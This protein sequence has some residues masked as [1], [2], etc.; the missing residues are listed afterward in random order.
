[1][2]TGFVL[3]LVQIG[4]MIGAIEKLIGYSWFSVLTSILPPLPKAIPMISM[5]DIGLA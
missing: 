3:S 5:I 1:M 2:S 4:G